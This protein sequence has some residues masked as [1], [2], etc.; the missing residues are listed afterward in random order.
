MAEHITAPIEN[1]AAFLAR[2][3]PIFA[4]SR[5]IK[6]RGAYM[7]SK[8]GH[9]AQ[10]RKVA[11]T[12]G[13]PERYFEHPR[14][15]A[16]IL[17]DE[18]DIR[19]ADLII[20]ALLHDTGEDTDEIDFELI[21]FFFG[22]DVA[23]MVRLLSKIPKDEYHERLERFADWRVLLVK[24][25]DRLHNIRSLE[26]TDLAFQ[27]KQLEETNREYIGLARRL[28]EIAPPE[29]RERA[30]RLLDL[31]TAAYTDRRRAF[32]AAMTATPLATDVDPPS[33]T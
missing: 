10:M 27:R 22:A 17:L 13:A 6:I 15:V 5:V 24:I 32:E 18:V 9:R 25:A 2:I 31:L 12:D 21:E 33:T 28:V 11:G 23:E 20:T 16:L 7:F 26:G 1:R 8:Y 14:H 3:E 29:H 30:Q 4:P 19:D